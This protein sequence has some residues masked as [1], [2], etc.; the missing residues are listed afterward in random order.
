MKKPG[1]E[2]GISN[3][4]ARALDTHPGPVWVERRLRMAVTWRLSK[5]WWY[6]LMQS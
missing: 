3:P 5:V 4:K 2:L 1:L 6:C